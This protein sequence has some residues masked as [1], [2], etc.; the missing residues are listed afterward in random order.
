M[1]MPLV[2]Y[3]VFERKGLQHS[4]VDFCEVGTVDKERYLTLGVQYRDELLDAEG[5]SILAPAGTYTAV[6]QK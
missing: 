1:G 3:K 5:Y 2:G 6:E 4:L